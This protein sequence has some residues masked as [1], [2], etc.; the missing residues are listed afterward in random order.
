MLFPHPNIPNPSPAAS[1]TS[2]PHFPR[3]HGQLP[4]SPAAPGRPA[5]L[6]RFGR[7]G[8]RLGEQLLNTGTVP[9]TGERNGEPMGFM[10][11]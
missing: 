9:E 7:Q 3:L 2:L 10:V 4:T 8:T 11:F 5:T 6:G 1:S